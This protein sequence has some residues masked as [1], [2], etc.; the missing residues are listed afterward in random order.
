MTADFN[1]VDAV[2]WRISSH[3]GTNGNCVEVAALPSRH[4]ALRDSKHRDGAVLVFSPAGWQAF[5]EDVR[6]G[7]FDDLA[8]ATRSA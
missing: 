2:R 7:E 1:G 4:V 8:T 5:M 3:S 6:N